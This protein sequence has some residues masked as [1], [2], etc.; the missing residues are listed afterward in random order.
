M[1]RVG[2]DPNPHTRWRILG[3]NRARMAM[4]RPTHLTHT[5]LHFLPFFSWVRE[6]CETRE[7]KRDGAGREDG[8]L[9]RV[10]GCSNPLA[11]FDASWDSDGLIELERAH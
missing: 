5:H 6:V 11:C 3:L 1:G 7:E 10:G 4:V 2:L 8:L 9:E